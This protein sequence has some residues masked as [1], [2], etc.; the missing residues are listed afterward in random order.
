VENL[1]V[2]QTDI[3]QV[4][5]LSGGHPRSAEYVIPEVMDHVYGPLV[6]KSKLCQHGLA[7]T[8]WVIKMECFVGNKMVDGV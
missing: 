7:K 4:L 8:V 6:G 2:R 3:Q 1:Y 5:Y